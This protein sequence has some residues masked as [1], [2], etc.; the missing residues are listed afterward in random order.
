MAD[1]IELTLQDKSKITLSTTH[2]VVV[3]ALHNGQTRI[4][5]DIP[6]QNGLQTHFFTDET[7]A[8]L[9]KRLGV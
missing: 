4:T 6:N 3:E 2:I 1:F 9:I 5:V 7:Y 8:S